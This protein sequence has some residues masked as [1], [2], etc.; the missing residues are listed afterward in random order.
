MN[1]VGFEMIKSGHTEKNKSEVGVDFFLDQMK[2]IPRSTV[3]R[4]RA[5]SIFLELRFEERYVDTASI[6]PEEG[7]SLFKNRL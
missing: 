2:K 6:T 5:F 3:F 1:V 4:K 7:K